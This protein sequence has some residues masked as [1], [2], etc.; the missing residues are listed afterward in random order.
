MLGNALR[1]GECPRKP[2]LPEIPGLLMISG[3]ESRHH[4]VIPPSVA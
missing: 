2:W 4:I 1:E 3:F